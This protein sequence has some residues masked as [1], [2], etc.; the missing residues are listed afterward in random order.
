MSIKTP[1]IRTVRTPALIA[2]A[3]L[4]LAASV[5]TLCSA[6]EASE[7]PQAI[8]KYADLD[9]STAGGAAT[10]FNRIRMASAGVCSSLDHGDFTAVFRFQACVKHAIEGAVLKVNRPALSAAYAAKYG[11]LEPAKILTAERR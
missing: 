5:S 11:A 8:V 9:L 3:I 1:S 2:S 6:S 7:A 10:L 4:A